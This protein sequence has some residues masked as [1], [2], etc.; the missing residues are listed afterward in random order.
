LSRSS[1]LNLNLS[2]NNLLNNTNIQ[3]GGYQ[4]G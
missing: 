3:T 4:Q 1:S 2:L